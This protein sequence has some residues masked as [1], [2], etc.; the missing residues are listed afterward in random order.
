MTSGD[1]E[2]CASSVAHYMQNLI[3][4]RLGAQLLQ[5]VD[6]LLHMYTGPS[7]A[8]AIAGGEGSRQS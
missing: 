4:H 2:E 6:V 1:Y 8:G 5:T 3:R 7:G